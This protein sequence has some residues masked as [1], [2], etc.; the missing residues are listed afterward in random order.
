MSV[1]DTGSKSVVSAGTPV[2]STKR[3][4]QTVCF[5]SGLAAQAEQ[6]R[7]KLEGVPVLFNPG[8]TFYAKGRE[9]QADP[10][11]AK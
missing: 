8:L 6:T 7:G 4:G 9:M 3:W 2:A 1:K 11:P 5:A 10:A